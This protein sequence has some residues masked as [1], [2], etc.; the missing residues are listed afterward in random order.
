MRPP[1]RAPA[2]PRMYLPHWVFQERFVRQSYS[3]RVTTE[4]S[5]ISLRSS[6][7]CSDRR[8]THSRGSSCDTATLAM[9]NRPRRA[10][11]C[12]NTAP[13]AVSPIRATLSNRYLKSDAGHHQDRAVQRRTGAWGA[14]I[15]G[16]RRSGPARGAGLPARGSSIPVPAVRRRATVPDNAGAQTVGAPR[17]R[18]FSFMLIVDS[19]ACGSRA[20]R[21]VPTSAPTL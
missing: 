15:R 16:L 20:R 3:V 8:H 19:L 1:N 7:R 13:T 2:A 21:G 14:V 4:R 18:A 10:L 6:L 5:S 9:G 11:T 12:T 17:H